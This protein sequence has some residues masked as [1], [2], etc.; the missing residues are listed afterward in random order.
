[1]HSI[2][3]VI[4]RTAWNADVAVGYGLLITLIVVAVLTALTYR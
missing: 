4:R 3:F 2:R 1:M